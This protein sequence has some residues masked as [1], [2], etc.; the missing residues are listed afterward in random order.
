M[1]SPIVQT[2]TDP[3]QGST[4]IGLRLT[5][6][7]LSSDPT[8]AVTFFIAVLFTGLL[9]TL[10]PGLFERVTADALDESL[11][12]ASPTT[13]NLD[14]GSLTRYGSARGD[15]PYGPVHDALVEFREEEIPFSIQSLIYDEIFVA[16]TPQF[17]VS[18]F[19]GTAARRFP[20]F[21]TLRYMDGIEENMILTSGRMPEPVEPVAMRVGPD[22]PP[23]EPGED[24]TAPDPS[25][26]QDLNDDGE[27][28]C[29][30][31]NVPRFQVAVS[32]PTLEALEV[33]LDDQIII[34]P[35]TTDQLF[36]RVPTAR[37]DY[38]LVIEVS[39]I[40]EPSDVAAEYWFGD[41]ALHRPRLRSNADFT[42]FFP[43]ALMSPD[44]HRDVG[45]ATGLA[46]WEYSFRYLVDMDQITPK[47]VE[48]L[49][50]DLRGLESNF[51]TIAPVGSG[52]F[53]LH[54]GL[55]ELLDQYR[56]RRQLTV[57]TVSVTLAGLFIVS[58]SVMFLLAALAAIRQR[59]S[60]VQLRSRGASKPQLTVTRALQ[61]VV[62]STPAVAVAYLAAAVI[63]PS[64]SSLPLQASVAL[65]AAAT[66][67]M[68]GAGAFYIFKSLG[69]LQRGVDPLRKTSPRRVVAELLVVT[70]AILAVFV[71][72]R[73]GF[74]DEGGS[75]DLLIAAGPALLAVAVG[76]LTL[77]M[78]PLLV[79]PVAWVGA[80]LKGMVT[81]VGFK[82]VL[83][84]APTARLPVTV[85]LLAAAMAVFASVVQTSITDGQVASTWQSVG[86]AHR[87]TTR[88]PGLA[89][90]SL[91]LDAPSVQQTAEAAKYASATVVNALPDSPRIADLIAIDGPAYVAVTTDT[92]ANPQFPTW[93][94]GGAAA[95]SGSEEHPIPVI[96]VGRW[97]SQESPTLGT[98]FGL[99]LDTVRP[100][101]IVR[102]LRSSFPGVT[103]TTPTVIA[104]LND[105]RAVENLAARPTDVFVRARADA[106]EELT[107]VLGPQNAVVRLTSQ[108]VLYDEI[109]DE[110]FA[111]AVETSLRLTFVLCTGFAVVAAVSSLALMADARRR[112]F[113]YLR[114]LGLNRNQGLALTMIEQ[115]PPVLI[116]TIVG[117]LLGVATARLLEPTINIG[118]FTGPGLPA[119]VQTDALLI[120][121]TGLVLIGAVSAS[122]VIFGIL[123]RRQDLGNLVKVGDE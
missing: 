38:R 107:H 110:P 16:D 4:A 115:M 62:L 112:D 96:I 44:V 84:L 121:A 35:D 80:R 61:G 99:S 109:R 117:T 58:L 48:D 67:L 52:E 56:E 50:A 15:D 85:I 78:Y 49:T 106:A 11:S 25:L 19:P 39:G 94:L 57:S 68:V 37:L 105:I 83:Q 122:V 1:P 26:L 31:V 9:L 76:I 72:R 5:M 53:T 51:Q 75:F 120:G 22:C 3:R 93:F 27:I 60:T 47:D 54:T 8:V 119:S 17:V 18:P 30:N 113:G 6:K 90:P 73:R 123:D 10:A 82:R 33:R 42:D 65:V 95:D 24:P 108:Q 40:I 55:T 101:F 45:R 87:V 71:L 70:T 23:V 114:T 74:D 46:S 116:A 89:L 100:M 28:E 12:T 64:E 118:A 79:R 43:T 32:Q 2:K 14:V 59:R 81:F 63:V 29:R 41:N 86:A 97:S 88:T 102:E 92:P 13:R 20:A 111:R 21:L 66:T 69:S 104:P 77:R 36:G 103:G 7:Q 91:D 98:T 34:R